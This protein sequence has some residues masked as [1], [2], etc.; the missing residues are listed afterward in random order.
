MGGGGIVGVGRG[1]WVGVGA[2]V[3]GGGDG[4]TSAQATVSNKTNG[5]QK[6]R[7]NLKWMNQRKLP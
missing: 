4:V 2:R 7:W 6:E 5:N 1:V 3:G